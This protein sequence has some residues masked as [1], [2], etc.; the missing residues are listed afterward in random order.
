MTVVT[1][2]FDADSDGWT[3]VGDVASD[4]WMATGGDPGGYFQWVDA[5]TGGEGLYNAPAKFLGDK[6]AFYGGS[7][8]YDLQDTGNNLTGADIVLAGGGL[9]LYYGDAG[10]PGI[11]PAWGTLSASL[12]AT[13]WTTDG[14]TA[15]TAQQMQTVLANLT[16]LEIRAEYVNGAESGGLDNVEMSTSSVCFARG[17]RLAT[18]RGEMEVEALKPGD[19]VL[20][21]SGDMRPVKWV[22]HRTINFRRHP[23]P[24][25][26]LPVR[27]A[28]GAFGRDRP[29][30]DLY[31]SPAHA[32]AVDLA[33]DILVPIGRL[34]NGATIAQVAVEAV[35]YW[36]VELDGHDILL[37]ENLSA[38]SYLDVG[39]RGFFVEAGL[40][41]LHPAAEAAPGEVDKG[42]FCR[43]FH[44]GGAVVKAIRTLL[45]ERAKALGWTLR[46]TTFGGLHLLVDGAR[47]EPETFDLVAHF[48][49]S[50]GARDIRLVS[51]TSRP[52]GHSQSEDERDLGL[53]LN[54]LVVEDRF[55]AT[56]E[57]GLDDARLQEGFHDF[58]GTHRWTSGRALLP[59]ELFAGD[60]CALRVHLHAPALAKW[61]APDETAADA[62]S[63]AERVA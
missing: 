59:A 62:S 17:T 7:I 12:T 13:G 55:G 52:D 28:A 18:S 20:T 37:A 21:A 38:E 51:E 48:P 29:S 10:T 58:E 63:R 31:L 42:R 11:T 1:S 15:A 44:E 36:H 40:I 33:G 47:V 43:P 16:S 35:E 27:I 5:V 8:T 54:R 23:R 30:R 9:T 45:I 50:P 34:V 4:G 32:V 14:T 53:C 39:N 57:I 61:V 24:S 25:E 2:T 22:G 46:T 49:I 60:G 6:S 19:L 26:A 3:M 56:R 41:A